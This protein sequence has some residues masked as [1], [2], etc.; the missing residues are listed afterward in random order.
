MT[1]ITIF[2]VTM[3]DLFDT[4]GIF[5]GTGKKAGIFKIDKDGNMPKKLEKAMIADSIGSIFGSFLGTSSVTTYLESSAGIEAGGRSGL[6]SIF[7]ALFFCLSLLLYPIVK[8]VPIQAV[9]PVLILIGVSMI[10]SIGKINWK[11]YLIAIPAFFCIVLMPFT[12]SISTGIEI[13]FILYALLNIYTNNQNK[14][15]PIIYIFSL[16]F[17]IKY[18]LVAF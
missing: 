5:I 8:C 7:I 10:Q 3:S 13:S 17:I 12:Y 6:T 15:S 2:S 18:I 14:V 1:L 16:L 11:D 9:S 4:I